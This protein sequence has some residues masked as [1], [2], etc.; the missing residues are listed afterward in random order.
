MKA[1]NDALILWLR[2]DLEKRL[3]VSAN[4]LLTQSLH[5]VA[6]VERLVANMAAGP[7][8]FTWRN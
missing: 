8:D 2:G 4:N 7:D 6:V 5:R 1:E 3:R